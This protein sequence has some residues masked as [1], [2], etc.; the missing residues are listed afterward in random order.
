MNLV[1]IVKILQNFHGLL[2]ECVKKMQEENKADTLIVLSNMYNYIPTFL[3]Q[4]TDNQKFI[5]LLQTKAFIMQ[6]YALVEQDKWDEML[7]I[8]QKA[9]D[10]FLL[11]INQADNTN[12]N[13]NTLNKIYIY[14]NEI[15]KTIQEKN[16][17]LYFVK[18]KNLVESITIEQE[19][20]KKIRT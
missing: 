10:T 16:K 7:S 4:V 9:I 12:A 13:V 8:I 2:D 1:S 17:E 19:N 5:S 3:S 6:S 15:K 14:L 20:F 11:V 18:Y